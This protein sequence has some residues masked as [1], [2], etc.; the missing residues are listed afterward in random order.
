VEEHIVIFLLLRLMWFVGVLGLWFFA[1]ADLLFGAAPMAN[2]LNNLLPR[3]VVAVV[4]PLAI[5]TPRGRYLLWA[6][7][8]HGHEE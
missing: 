1:L 2:R 5:I 6:R 8:Q 3:V 7:W 4:W